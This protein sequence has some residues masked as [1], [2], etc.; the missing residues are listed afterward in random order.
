VVLQV[1]KLD[2]KIMR[3]VFGMQQLELKL[4]H[5]SA[6]DYRVVVLPLIKSFLKVGIHLWLPS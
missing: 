4:G 1:S 3:N 5:L 2:A 6:F